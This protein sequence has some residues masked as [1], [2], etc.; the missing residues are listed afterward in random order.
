MPYRG[1]IENGAIVLDESVII[2]EGVEVSVLVLE[3]LLWQL[4]LHWF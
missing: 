2:P 3:Q 1:H 4:S